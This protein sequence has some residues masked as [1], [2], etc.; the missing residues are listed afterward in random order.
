MFLEKMEKVLNI[1]YV[2]FMNFI[3]KLMKEFVFVIEKGFNIEEKL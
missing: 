3:G 1:E 2:G